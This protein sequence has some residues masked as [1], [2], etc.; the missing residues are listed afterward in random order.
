MQ[1]ATA[2]RLDSSL[3]VSPVLA[4]LQAANLGPEPPPPFLSQ[5]VTHRNQHS[6][7]GVKQ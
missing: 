4:Q 2:S 1:G 3:Q 5:L 7:A 6:H